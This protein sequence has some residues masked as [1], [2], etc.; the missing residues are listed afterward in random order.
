MDE[1]CYINQRL[2]KQGFETDRH[3]A[4]L[5]AKAFEKLCVAS[6]RSPIQLHSVQDLLPV[7]AGHPEL[8]EVVR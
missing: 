2:V 5:L 1:H 6:K 3:S 8:M 7:A 4:T